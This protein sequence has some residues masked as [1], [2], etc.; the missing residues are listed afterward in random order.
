MTLKPNPAGA[1][2]ICEQEKHAA[3]SGWAATK[4]A[5]S[6]EAQGW[7]M[8]LLTLFPF[9]F[10]ED[11]SE[12]HIQYW[13][14][15]WSVLQR[16]KQ[17]TVVPN[18]ELVALLILGRGLGKS[19]VLECA[20]VMRGA[21]LNKGYSLI[22]SETDDQAQEHL[23][24]VRILIEHPDSHLL[25][26]YPQM[27]IAD[28]ADAL[29]GMPTADRKE[30]FICKNGWICRSKGLNAKMRGLRVGIHRPDDL[31]FDDID[32]V[33]DSL[34]LS[35]SKERQ[36]TASILPVQA[37]ADVTIDTGQNLI[38]EHSFVNRVFTGKTDALAERTLIGVS[39]AF[40]HLKIDSKIDNKGRMRHRIA[41]E[42]M[43]SWAGLNVLRAQKFLD[44]S[45]LQTFLAE[46]QNEFG[47]FKAGK[48]ISNYNETAQIIT[49]SMFA[50]LFGQRRIPRHWKSK[51]GL[52]VGYS[53]GLYP[54]YSAWIFVAT[55]AMN[56]PLPNA[57]FL[58]RGR[59]FKGTSID[60]QAAII[61]SEMYPDECEMI[62][63]WQ[64]SHERTGEMLTLRQ[65]YDLPFS[66]FQFYKAEDGVAQWKHLSMCDY[67]QPNPFK[68]DEKM[69]E[70]YKI[71]R[72][73]LFYIVD[74]DQ[75]VFA[76]NDRGLSLFRDQVSTWEYVPVKITEQGQT[77]QKP[78]K[79]N[80]DF[81]DAFKSTIAMFGAEALPLTDKELIEDA[82]PA[83]YKMENL[84]KKSPYKKHLSDSQSLARAL[85]EMEVKEQ[86]GIEEDYERD[87]DG[88]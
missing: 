19:S 6:L 21:I 59:S 71:G 53:E 56:S 67:S 69:G 66:K 34:A 46:Y 75:Y 50:K 87:D 11:F 65:K 24:N 44:D 17:G 40:T 8:W 37:R 26:Y 61:K 49:W 68:P 20:R 83:P 7:K 78:S 10:E 23:G 45:G 25:E 62:D 35:L 51:A 47:Q 54:H 9:W 14:L 43:P 48:V 42:S 82:M 22:I 74:D 77:I 13:E 84:L 79:M 16:I 76:H 72:P 5:K 64:M 3:G 55:A 29:K 88:W 57:K 28:N 30:M 31:C 27:A 36:I 63:T 81:M 80:D 33:N 18:K 52:D 39:N 41:E 60:D 86:L 1:I 73:Q 2:A 15:R 12:D 85:M 32:D 4:D 38:S 58:Y 70:A